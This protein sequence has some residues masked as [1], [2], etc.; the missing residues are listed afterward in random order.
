M[1]EDKWV[2]IINPIAG[3]GFAAEM[4]SV[5]KAEVE[6]RGINGEIV[7]TEKHGHA[8]EIS[9]RYASAGYRYIIGVGGDGT[10]NEIAA[11]LLH[12]K[13]VVA[14]I[15]PAGSGNDFIQITGFPSRF[16]AENW[17]SFFR[18]ETIA[19]D[20]G[21]CNGKYFFNGLGLGFDANVASKNY[22]AE[23]ELQRGGKYKYIWHILGTILF[24]REKRMITVNNDS[25]NE[26]D[27]FINT[28]SNGRRYAGGFLLTPEAIANDGL[29]DVCNIKRLGL[30]QRLKILSMVPKGRHLGDK[31]VNYYRTTQLE[32][33]FGQ[34]VPYHLDGEVFFSERFDIR[35]IPGALNIIYNPSGRHF[36]KIPPEEI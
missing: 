18:A 22:T 29:L 10:F 19:I 9:E 12:K 7:F 4:E 28:V 13:N 30:L 11:P 20:A 35:I 5:I 8:P 36:L 15:I 33:E 34:K 1:K 16:R 21:F 31:R 24:Y 14:G 27:C 3:N 25:R 6:K 32:L 26:D 17:N 23:G 2:F